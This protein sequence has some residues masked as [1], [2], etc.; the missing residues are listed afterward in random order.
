MSLSDL[1][2]GWLDP[3]EAAVLSDLA[4]GLTVLELGAYM[5]RSTVALA[6]SA[7]L[8]VSVD[9]HQG[10]V[11]HNATGRD[12]LPEYLAHVRDLPNVVVVIGGFDL[13]VPLLGRHFDLVFVDGDHDASSVASDALHARNHV[14]PG[15]WV[16]FHDWDMESVRAGASSSPW[17][18][19]PDR[20][21]GSLAVFRMVGGYQ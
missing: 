7:S 11:G 17:F 20:V 3:K 1:P 13:I 14:R 6:A 5:G 8:V 4:S 16:C 2:F 19:T 15:G 10:V 12:S 18:V 21:V 9:R